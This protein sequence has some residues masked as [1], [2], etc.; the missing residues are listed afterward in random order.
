MNI[1][2]NIITIPIDGN[3][4]FTEFIFP[5]GYSY[6]KIF[7]ISNGVYIK[8]PNG[9]PLPSNQHIT[10]PIVNGKSPI[11]ISVAN[12]ASNSGYALIIIEEFGGEPDLTYFNSEFE[13][14]VVKRKDG[15][16]YKMIPERNHGGD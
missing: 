11:S 9:K 8:F 16:E 7:I 1:N 5:D 2:G 4:P 12:T 14:I 15:S 13:P 6:H 10:I 3:T